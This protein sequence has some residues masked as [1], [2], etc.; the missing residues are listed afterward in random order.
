MIRFDISNE[1]EKNSFADLLDWHSHYKPMKC[2]ARLKS[3]ILN[4]LIEKSGLNIN[5]TTTVWQNPSEYLS[6]SRR[7]TPKS[8]LNKTETREFY[9]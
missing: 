7:Y 1:E 4:L 2:G 6:T 8:N 3:A 5:E 9:D